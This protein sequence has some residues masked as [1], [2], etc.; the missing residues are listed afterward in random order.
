MPSVGK[1]HSG[2][3]SDTPD[4]DLL[5][6]PPPE[7]RSEEATAS[8]VVAAWHAESAVA[9]SFLHRDGGRC[10]CVYLATLAVRAVRADG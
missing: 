9:E 3:H 5:P 2:V 8:A 6:V 1:D 7:R 10:F 4:V